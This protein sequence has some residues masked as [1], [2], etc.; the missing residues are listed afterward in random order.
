MSNWITEPFRAQ[1][2]DEGLV[3]LVERTIG[4]LWLVTWCSSHMKA[5]RAF[6]IINAETVD[7]VI[8]LVNVKAIH[9]Q[10]RSAHGPLN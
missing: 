2:I 5:W 7:D 4:P 9:E 10:A 3:I 8:K 1:I 6:G